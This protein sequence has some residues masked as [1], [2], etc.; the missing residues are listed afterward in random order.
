MSQSARECRQ[1]WRVSHAGTA[2][3]GRLHRRM[4][5]QVNI[6]VTV[7]CR[8]GVDNEDSDESLMQYISIKSI[9]SGRLQYFLLSTT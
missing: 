3:I 6:P 7:K 1:I 5:A 4:R 2:A 8:I 9:A